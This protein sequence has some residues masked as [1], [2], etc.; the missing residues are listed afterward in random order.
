MTLIGTIDPQQLGLPHGASVSLAFVCP[1]MG[2]VS[3]VGVTQQAHRRMLFLASRL[4]A[5]VSTPLF[6]KLSSSFARSA[7]GLTR[8]T[9][10]APIF[11]PLAEIRKDRPFPMY[12]GDSQVSL[13]GVYI[14]NLT[15]DEIVLLSQA[16]GLIGSTSPG[17]AAADDRYIE[18]SSPGSDGKA[19]NRQVNRQSLGM[20]FSGALGRNGFWALRS[21]SLDRGSCGR[22][23]SKLLPADG[24]V[25]CFFDG[26]RSCPSL[27]FGGGLRA[28]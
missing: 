28:H 1:G 13:W 19:L 12:G 3:S 4:P 10:Y 14:D 23:G 9:S 21:G 26:P 22:D 6:E 7:V 5:E 17:M 16:L 2:W 11:D 27:G 15:Q 25:K 24:F 20:R 18:W 8:E